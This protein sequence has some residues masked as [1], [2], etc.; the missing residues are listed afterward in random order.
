MTRTKRL[1]V[2]REI[3]IACTIPS[4]S[5][6]VPGTC[7]SGDKG[8]HDEVSRAGT[9]FRNH[10][11]EGHE[12]PHYAARDTCQNG[13]LRDSSERL[14]FLS[15]RSWNKCARP[16]HFPEKYDSVRAALAP[17]FPLVPYGTGEPK[18]AYVL[19]L[20]LS[21]FLLLCIPRA[22][23]TCTLFR[24]GADELWT[25][26]YRPSFESTR[27]KRNEQ[28]EFSIIYETIQII[29]KKLLS[30]ARESGQHGLST[31]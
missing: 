10:L 5:V 30:F 27:R 13:G 23:C 6:I 16:D 25:F 29:Q 12:D 18:Y 24:S 11:M 20:F 8:D 15:K 14:R 31:S 3:D 19:C 1:R 21:L 2:E 28:V 26:P 9:S 22:K 17:D 7:A 4:I